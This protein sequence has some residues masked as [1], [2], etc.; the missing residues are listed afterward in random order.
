MAV[1]RETEGDG[2]QNKNSSNGARG[3]LRERKWQ[4]RPKA[5]HEPGIRVFAS[6]RKY[7]DHR[8]I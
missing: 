5:K 8:E 2:L 7:T 4:G 3:Q 1:G 6:G